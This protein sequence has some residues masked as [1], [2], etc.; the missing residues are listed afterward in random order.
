MLLPLNLILVNIVLANSIRTLTPD[1]KRTTLP[2]S[3]QMYL[4]NSTRAMACNVT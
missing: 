2:G 1:F 3:G 4:I